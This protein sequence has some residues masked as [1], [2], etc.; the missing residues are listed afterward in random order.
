MDIRIWWISIADLTGFVGGLF[1]KED[2]WNTALEKARGII[3]EEFHKWG[4]VKGISKIV[5]PVEL[6][7]IE[8]KFEYDKWYT[9][10]TLPD[11]VEQI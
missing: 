3:P 11:D 9:G 7:Q 5:T 8:E 4:Q 2:D 6:K 10:D 1:I